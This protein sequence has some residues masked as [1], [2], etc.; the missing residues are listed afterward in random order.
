MQALA[1]E[2]ALIG[3]GQ[4]R[5]ARPV[6][7]ARSGCAFEAL[8]ARGMSRCGFNLVETVWGGPS[9]TARSELL[10]ECG[11]TFTGARAAAISAGNER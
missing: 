7:S 11:V 4:R 2:A 10:A 9:M 8:I 1:I 3:A 5:R 6:V